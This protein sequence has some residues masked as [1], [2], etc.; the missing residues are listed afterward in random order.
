MS[1]IAIFQIPVP[2][3]HRP[4]DSPVNVHMTLPDVLQNALVG[5]RFAANIV[6]LGKTVHGDRHA[7]SGNVHPVLRNRDHSTGDNHSVN[8]HLAQYRQQPA[9]FTM[10][11]QRLAADEG[12]VKRTMLTN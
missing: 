11:Y 2:G 8:F 12:Q 1:Q 3:D 10:P 6:M 4:G 9:Q 5:G 7:Q